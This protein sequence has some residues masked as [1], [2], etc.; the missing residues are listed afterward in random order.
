MKKKKSVIY[1]SLWTMGIVMVLAVLILEMVSVILIKKDRIKAEGLFQNTITSYGELWEDKLTSTSKSLLIMVG[2]NSTPYYQQ[3]C[4]SE[5]PLT[6]ETGKIQQQDI[7]QEMNDRYGREMTLF[8][9]VPERQIYFTSNEDGISYSWQIELKKQIEKYIKNKEEEGDKIWNFLSIDQHSY[10]IRTFS[11]E[12]GYIGAVVSLDRIVKKFMENSKNMRMEIQDRQGNVKTERGNNR[13]EEGMS[14]TYSLKNTEVQLCVS[15][16]ENIAGLGK[17]TSMSF[18]MS[19]GIFLALSSILLSLG[20]QSKNVFLPLEKL[21]MAMEQYSMGK[22]DVRLPETQ[23]NFQ[24]GRL[25]QTF[26]HMADQIQ[27]LRLD[28]YEKE[29]ERQKVKSHYLQVQIQP[30]FY[31]NILNLIHGLA[32]IQDYPQIQKLCRVSAAYFRYLMGR[33]GT[34][35]PLEE[36]LKC[37]M[38]YIEI[39][40][41]RYMGMLEIHVDVEGEAR[42]VMIL[43]LVIQ[44]FVGNSVKHNIMQVP[45][46]KIEVSVRKENEKRLEIRIRDNG[47]GFD[48]EVLRK[49]NNNESLEEEG[50]HIGIQNI[51]ERIQEFYGNGYNFTI[52]SRK[53]FSEVRLLLLW[54]EKEMNPE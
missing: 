10:L 54:I 44:T 50:E 5:D 32:Q 25:Y 21:R 13:K 7:M 36:E 35:V 24:I 20:L 1:K 34:F 4:L 47:I 33:K 41:V 3:L 42:N 48:P 19:A 53:G 22:V 31:A 27:K 15:M 46:L 6:V 39:Q 37:L 14:Y 12:K 23:E 40:H 2:T 38:N 49:I 11:S 8:V 28:V 18:L 51:K 52:T 45:H 26:N 16:D 43:P 17:I 30:H 29:L 9:Y